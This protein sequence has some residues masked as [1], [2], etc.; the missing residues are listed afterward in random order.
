MLNR[1]QNI[2]IWYFTK[3]TVYKIIWK[4]DWGLSF[5]LYDRV[6]PGKRRVRSMEIMNEIGRRSDTIQ[7]PLNFTTH[8]YC[9]NIC[10]IS[11]KSLLLNV[12]S[13]MISF[14]YAPLHEFIYFYVTEKGCFLFLSLP[15]KSLLGTTLTSIFIQVAF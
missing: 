10:F 14:G 5:I 3:Y 6:K 9:F 11:F 1:N 15:D 8:R 2:R 12:W 13:K 4:R 7:P